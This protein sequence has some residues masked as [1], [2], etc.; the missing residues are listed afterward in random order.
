M[1]YVYKMRDYAPWPSY[2]SRGAAER[3]LRDAAAEWVGS[4]AH[5]RTEYDVR[6]GMIEAD[7]AATQRAISDIHVT[8]SMSNEERGEMSDR[9]DTLIF[10]RRECDQRRGQVIA[11]R[12]QLHVEFLEKYACKVIERNSTH[13]LIAWTTSEGAVEHPVPLMD[14]H[15][16]AVREVD[17]PLSAAEDMRIR[18]HLERRLREAPVEI[19]SPLLC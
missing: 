12:D 18:T 3:M 4:L 10:Q 15:G 11:L 5:L 17:T 9:L 14:W 16:A 1:P 2:Q 8:P 19:R 6:I 13:Y 7:A